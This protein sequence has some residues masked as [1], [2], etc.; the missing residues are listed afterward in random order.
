MG[1]AHDS[2]N[3]QNH[4]FLE[5]GPDPQEIFIHFKAASEEMLWS[6]SH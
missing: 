6:G 5:G 1:P 3:L 4:N 2:A